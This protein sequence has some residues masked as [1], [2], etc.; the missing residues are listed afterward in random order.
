MILVVNADGLA[1]RITIDGVV[2]FKYE[3][4]KFEFK[5]DLP[6]HEVAIKFI[7]DKLIEKNIIKNIDD[8]SGVGFRVVHGS[9]ISKSSI[10]D[11]KV[12]EIIKDAVK[13]APLHNPGAITAIEAVQKIM[14]K[15]K[16]VACFDTA[17]HTD[18]PEKNYIYP[19]PYE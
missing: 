16:M 7:L 14:P 9:N 17:F 15:A 18:I 13:L 3:N 6:N 2:G 4:E 1:E 10:I 11:K 5:T 8:I 12:F 19:T